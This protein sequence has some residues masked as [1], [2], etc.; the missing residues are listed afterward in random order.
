MRQARFLA[1]R[2]LSL[3]L[4]FEVASDVIVATCMS[5]IIPPHVTGFMALK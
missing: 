3:G 4:V 2:H 1:D 5:R